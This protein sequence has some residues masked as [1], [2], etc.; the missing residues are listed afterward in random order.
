MKVAEKQINRF[1]IS[2]GHITVDFIESVSRIQND[3][4]ITGSDEDRNRIARFGI[5]PTV[6][7]QKDHFH[8][9]NL[10]LTRRE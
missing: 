9:R 6:G 2:R 3:V 8:G 7:A 1:L 4:I 10:L 5:V